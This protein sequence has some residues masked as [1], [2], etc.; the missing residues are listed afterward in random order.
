MI[1]KRLLNHVAAILTVA[2]LV[3]CRHGLHSIAL[4]GLAPLPRS[5]LAE[6]VSH[7]APRNP[8]RY[9]LRWRF[10]NDQ[11]A[12]GGRAVV[13][14][15]PPD[16][17]RLDFRGPFGKS[18][19]A[20]VVGDSGVWSKPEGDFRD[21]LRSAPLFWAALGMPLPPGPRVETGGL[22]RPDGRAWRYATGQD[23][24]DFVEVRA[25]AKLLAETRRGGRIVGLAEAQF[26]QA[27]RRVV[28]SRLD[29]PVAQ[30]RFTFSVSAVDTSAVFSSEIWRQP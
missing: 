9:E 2:G 12:A 28:A 21:V 8:V 30:S 15:V 7:Y 22:D 13:R 23:T 5:T 26:D 14:I 11:G 3:G 17:L 10:Q 24:T 16:S 4:V 1:E 25:P 18:G 27:G 19:A 20:V 29:F 6:W